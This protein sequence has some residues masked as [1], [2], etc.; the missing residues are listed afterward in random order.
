MNPQN[1][2]QLNQQLQSFRKKFYTDKIIRGSLI[3][4]L[5]ISSMLF[6]ALLSEGLF[7]FSTSTRTVIVFLLA[8]TFLGT[9][10]YMVL[11]PAYQLFNQSKGISDFQIADMVR[12]FFPNVNDKLTNL[13][14]LRRS[15]SPENMLAVAAI[16]QKAA[17]IAPVPLKNAINLNLNKRYLYLLLIPVALYLLTSAISPGTLRAGREHLINYNRQYT[18]PAP[19]SLQLSEIPTSLVAGQS[20]KVEVNVAQGRALPEELYMFIRGKGES[21]F[22]DYSMDKVSKTSYSYTFNNVKEDFSFMV[23]DPEVKSNEYQI[24]VLKRPFIKKFNVTINYPAYTGLPAE[25]L[26]DNIG[27]FKALKGSLVTWTVEPD[28]KVQSAFLVGKGKF[29]F[30]ATTDKDGLKLSRSLTE[31]LQY[32]ISLKSPDNISNIDTVRYRADVLAD[33]FPSIYVF[34]PNSDFIVNLDMTLPLDMEV[35]DDFGFSK[36]TLYYRFTKSGGATSVSK[37]FMEFPLQLA[38]KTLV[39]PLRY[40]LD[41]SQLGMKEG[42]E[43][44][45]YLKVWDNDGVSGPKASTSATFRAMYPT[46][47]AKYDEVGEAQEDIKEK[48]DDLKKQSKEL[49]EKY[50]KMQEKLLEKKQLSFDDRKEIQKMLEAHQNMMKELQET[51]QKME[52]VKKELENNSM[53]SEETLEKYEELNKFL[54]N[55]ENEELRKMLE[56]MQKQMENLSPEEIREKLEKLQMN[57]EDLRKSLERT[58]E[59]FKQ[60]EVNQKIDEIRN[61]LQNLESKQELLNE[62][63]EQADTKNKEQM[64]QLQERQKELEKQ[65]ES[66]QKDIEDLQKMKNDT[67]TPDK[68]G[69]DEVNKLGDEAKKEMDNAADQMKEASE[70]SE[71]G[72]KNKANK[73]QSGASGSQKKA[74]GK[75]KEMSDKLA[76]MQQNMQSMQDQMNLESLRELLENL[77]RLSFDQEDLKERV[78]KMNYGD[79]A[80]KDRSQNQKKL[81]DDMGLVRDSLEALAKREFKIQKFVLDESATITDNMK[82]SQTFFRNKQVPMVTYHQ[83]T[84]MTSINNLANMLSDVMKQIQEQ[85]MNAKP[86]SGMCPSPGQKPGDMQGMSE[87][88]KQ[89]NQ[90]LQQM[91]NGMGNPEK[92]SQMAAQQEAIRK[93]LEERMNKIKEEGGSVLGDME[94][95]KQD[96]KD[97]ENELR[98]KILTEQTLMRQQ[99]ILSRLLYAEKSMREREMDNKRESK[100]GQNFDRKSPEELTKEEYRNKI[101]QELLRSNQLEYSADYL[102]LI[103]QYYKKLEANP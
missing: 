30:L 84:A 59:L 79:P 83:Q 71:Q 31:D 88:Q 39:Q 54:E 67:K 27:D 64:D 34:S 101:R 35:S 73:A 43:L 85:M 33:R 74:G 99:Q 12:R 3:L 13:L 32:F 16:D 23:G 102:R 68:E 48:V 76:G 60:L 7:G 98:N 103:E 91:K 10:G 61:K 42:D 4:A 17:E 20:F 75:M 2:L 28:E 38:K 77:L 89:L 100:T 63:T 78:R 44:E 55:L 72:N 81:Q 82:K 93:S 6:V 24:K 5:L 87:S 66:V 26:E 41:L 9:L 56:E 37:E 96:M 22:I 1:Q 69:M 45:Y 62:K 95:V 92:L 51:Q 19:F 53:I 36:M 94:K 11:W 21:G 65:M 86:G 14:Q 80:L 47:D 58:L 46:L 15:V 70:Q 40:G 52:Q 8:A 25:R 18:P 90:Q 97:T 57:D 49:E 50:R 29:P